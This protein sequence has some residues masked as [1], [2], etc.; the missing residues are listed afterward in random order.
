MKKLIACLLSVLFLFSLVACGDRSPK[1]EQGES[2][3][4][5]TSSQKDDSVFG[6][7]DAAVFKNLKFTATELKESQGKNFINPAEGKVYV[8]VKFTIENV[9]NEEQAVSSLMLFEAY[10]DDVKADLSIMASTVFEEGTLDGTL[11]PGKKLVGWYAVEI[12]ENWA[13]LELEVKGDWLSDKS[14]TFVFNK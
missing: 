14:A 10:A 12:P 7:N 2:Q 6:L 11:A 3:T 9:S 5:S 13:K 1:K 8:G 4:Q